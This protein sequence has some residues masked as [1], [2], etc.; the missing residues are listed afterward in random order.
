MPPAALLWDPSGETLPVR[1]GT[2]RG[3]LT[4]GAP[5]TQ[6]SSTYA[7]LLSEQVGHEFAASQQYIAIAV[8]ADA[9]D[10]AQLAARVSRHSPGERTDAATM[11][12]YLLDPARPTASPGVAPPR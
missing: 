4:K 12:Q 3:G 11:V 5:M 10:L 8:W 1:L 2:C 9:Q 7:E 6:S